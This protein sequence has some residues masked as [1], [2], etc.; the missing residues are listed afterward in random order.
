MSASV[1]FINTGKNRGFFKKNQCHYGKL[2]SEFFGASCAPGALDFAHN[3]KK[4]KESFHSDNLCELCR[5]SVSVS[6]R[7]ADASVTLSTP[8]PLFHLG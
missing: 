2:L 1:A 5:P 6:I 3:P 7:S 4:S 8:P